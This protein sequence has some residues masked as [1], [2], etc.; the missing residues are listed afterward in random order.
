METCRTA[1]NDCALGLNV[2]GAIVGPVAAILPVDPTIAGCPPRP[3]QIAAA[4][5]EL[6]DR[7]PEPDA[8]LR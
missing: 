2:I 6:V 7:T 3:D 5:L 8:P 4:L 1:L